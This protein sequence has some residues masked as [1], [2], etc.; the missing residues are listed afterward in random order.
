MYQLLKKEQQY[1]LS[2]QFG[3]SRFFLPLAERRDVIRPS[4]HA[5]LFQNVQEVS[6][7]DSVC[8]IY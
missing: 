2:L 5:I 3:I 8:L 6:I 4:E 1:A 7:T